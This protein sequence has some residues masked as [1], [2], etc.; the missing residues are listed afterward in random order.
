MEITDKGD[1]N[2][3]FPTTTGTKSCNS[4]SGVQTLNKSGVASKN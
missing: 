2:H 1:P 4:G 3:E